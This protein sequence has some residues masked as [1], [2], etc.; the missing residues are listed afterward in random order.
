LVLLVLL[1]VMGACASGES[2]QETTAPEVTASAVDSTTIPL[3][4]VDWRD[5]VDGALGLL[6]ERHYQSET[7]DW[8]PVRD[9]AW[10]VLGDE[11]TQV[12]A[13]TAIRLAIRE[14]RVSHTFFLTPDE[15]AA[16]SDDSIEVTAPTGRVVD[17]R[18]GYLYLPGTTGSG[19]VG[20]LYAT[21]LHEAARL[22]STAGVCGWVIDLRD[23]SGGSMVPMLLGI[24]PFLR[25]GVFLTTFRPMTG[26][27]NAYSY[28]AGE[29]FINSEPADF[30]ETFSEQGMPEAAMGSLLAAFRLY[31]EPF[32]LTDSNP[33]V[34]VLTSF[35]TASAGEAVAISFRGRDGTMFFGEPTLGVPTGNSGWY[36]ADG[37]VLVITSGVLIDRNDAVYEGSLQPDQIV[38]ERPDTE[39]DEALETATQWLITQPAC[40]R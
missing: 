8:A 33:P 39:V 26:E 23:N 19:E 22:A 29:L 10:E 27:R 16:L 15:A 25:G 40:E 6:E 35:R 17:G 24:G 12:R 11:P 38:I 21:A 18:I 34:A 14:M 36:L 5:Y 9:V 20:R 37:A 32:E 13:H 31:S 1:N 2:A 28:Q 4:V 30:R 7:I 3:G